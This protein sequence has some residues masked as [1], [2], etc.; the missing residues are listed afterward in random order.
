MPY[1]GIYDVHILTIF[2]ARLY[3][4]T[5]LSFLLTKGLTLTDATA[6]L[7]AHSLGDLEELLHY[8]RE[9]ILDIYVT[10]LNDL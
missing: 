8:V 3:T 2:C 7:G 5:K 9:C 6:L 10:P 1:L 4:P